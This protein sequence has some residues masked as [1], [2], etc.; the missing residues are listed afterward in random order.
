M[1]TTSLS[2]LFALLAVGCSSISIEGQFLEPADVTATALA[3]SNRAPP[4][5]D[6]GATAAIERAVRL[7]LTAAAPTLTN[8]PAPSPGAFLIAFPE[9]EAVEG[10]EWPEGAVVHLAI[11]DLTTAASPDFEQDGTMAMTTWGDPRTCVSFDFADTYDLK[12]GDI[13]MVT[14]GTTGRTHVVRSLSVT[15]VDAA[16]DTVAGTADAGA[17]IQVWPHGFDP[18]AT[19]QVTAGADGAWLAD[20]RAV[21]FDLEEGLGGRSRIL[22]EAG[23]ATAV[24]WT[25]P[26]SPPS[27]T[28]EP[29]TAIPPTETPV[30]TATKKPAPPATVT[31]V[32]MAEP[33]TG[34]WAGPDPMD[35][36]I[37][38]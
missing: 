9:F 11:D 25:A 28:A 29:T 23:N 3:A 5:S 17:V 24:D 18:I 10:W 4:T 15:E 30:P 37:T 7:T 19:V 21:G 13:V 35:G 36:S 34:T 1:K 38:T 14:D 12:M 2:L 32:P 33:F 22:D 8:T 31:P 6:L 16:A 27:P 20:F 26:A